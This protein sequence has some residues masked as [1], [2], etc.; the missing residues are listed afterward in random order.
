[1]DALIFEVTLL[2]GDIGDQLLMDATPDIGEI[3][4]MHDESPSFE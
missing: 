1:V 2:I 3:D 4:R